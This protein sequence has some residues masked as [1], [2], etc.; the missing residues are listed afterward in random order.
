MGIPPSRPEPLRILLVED[1]PEAAR[2]MGEALREGAGGGVECEW[3]DRLP[4]ALARLAEGGVD[5]VVLDLAL[6]D[7]P[8]VAA[9]R[10]VRAAAEGVAIVALADADEGDAARLEEAGAQECLAPRWADGEPLRRATRHAAARRRAERL[11]AEAQRARAT[12]DVAA[13]TAHHLNNVFAVILGRTQLLLREVRATPVLEALAVVER[14]A[15]AGAEAVRRIQ[16]LTAST[17]ASEAVPVDVN[18]VTREALE[19][20]RALWHDEAE[21]HGRPIEARADL[22]EV[23]SVSGLAGLLR[24]ALVHLV[25]NAIDALP[26]GGRITARTWSTG[27]EVHCSVADTGVGMTDEVRRRAPVPFFTT[28]GS[29]HAGLGLSLAVAIVR[30]HGG[31]VAIDSA[32]GRGT[33][34]TVSLPAGVAVPAGGATRSE[35]PEPLTILLIDDDAEVR[36]VFADMLA[37]EGHAVIQAPGGRAALDRLARGEA[38]DLVL[39]DL[40]MSG[41]TGWEVARAVK[42]RWPSLPVGLVTGWGERAHGTAEERSRVD[43][44]LAKPFSPD[45][46][47]D[48]LARVRS[49]A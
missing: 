31:E 22:G 10:R 35:A 23:P 33:V 24:E 39:T 1:D 34:V 17:T 45:T 32:P 48:A 12:A 28:K 14:A 38:V 47:R 37:T 11:L 26:A 3:R 6:P 13:A 41:M 46:L 43:F 44:V 36:A 29:D 30:R 21:L 7:A 16:E 5:V 20:T 15:R 42:A 4:P 2:R 49:R 18:R 25:R 19:L 8:G 40:G 9:L 27:R